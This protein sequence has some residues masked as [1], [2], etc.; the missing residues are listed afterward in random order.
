MNARSYQHYPDAIAARLSIT[1]RSG[2]LDEQLDGRDPMACIDALAFRPAL[3]A[4]RILEVS[5]PCSIFVNRPELLLPTFLASKSPV[6][7][8]GLASPHLGSL[9]EGMAENYIRAARAAGIKDETLV[10]AMA[11]ITSPWRW[12]A[13]GYKLKARTLARATPDE[14]LSRLYEYLQAGGQAGGHFPGAELLKDE[15]LALYVDAKLNSDRKNS[16][17]VEWSLLEDVSVCLAFNL[18]AQD[19]VVRSNNA[20]LSVLLGLIHT[21]RGDPVWATEYYLTRVRTC[22]EDFALWVPD[23]EYRE[24]ESAQAREELAILFS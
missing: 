11:C 15:D 4:R 23:R 12:R 7:F 17:A 5:V 9:T 21:L 10:A 20:P 1:A 14:L 19:G 22:A 18:L 2:G 16:R 24:V 3:L 6:D 8:V 13:L